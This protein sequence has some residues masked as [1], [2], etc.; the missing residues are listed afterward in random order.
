MS[1]EAIDPIRE[2][3]DAAW[4]QSDADGITNGLAED[5]ILMPPNAPKQVGREQINSWLRELFRHY[6]MTELAMPE[7]ELTVSGDLGVERSV[8]EWTLTPTEGGQAIHDRANWVGI[9]RQDSSGSW[10]EVCGIWNSTLPLGTSE[11]MQRVEESV[12]G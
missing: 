8:Y 12:P 4:L 5:A 6:T 1:R 11:S 10:A 9:W 7:R 2:R 3:I